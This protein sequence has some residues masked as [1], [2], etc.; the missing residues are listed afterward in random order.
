MYAEVNVL[1][2]VRPDGERYVFLYADEDK[3][4]VL[5]VLGRFASDPDLSFTWSDAAKL[6]QRI[7]QQAAV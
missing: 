3:E 5:Q 6:A 1:A 2:L 4:A 7:R